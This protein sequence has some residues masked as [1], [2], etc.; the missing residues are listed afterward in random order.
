MMRPLLSLYCFVLVSSCPR[1]SGGLNS[2]RDGVDTEALSSGSCSWRSIR[3][4]AGCLFE[5]GI[6]VRRRQR[7]DAGF[8]EIQGEWVEIYGSFDQPVSCGD[9][10]KVCGSDVYCDCAS[11]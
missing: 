9:S 11:P 3:S 8:M 5:S 7:A 1:A 2:S 10:S 6:V 4:D